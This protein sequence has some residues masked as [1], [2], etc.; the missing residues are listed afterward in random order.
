MSKINRYKIILREEL[1]SNRFV[2]G[3]TAGLRDLDC[4]DE[5]VRIGIFE[6]GR[7]L[8]SFGDGVILVVLV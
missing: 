7:R 5:L 3:F 4:D 1:L 6:S 2:V 8:S